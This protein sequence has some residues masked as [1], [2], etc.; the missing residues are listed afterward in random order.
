MDAR[1]EAR[2]MESVS[3][4][5]QSGIAQKRNGS[6]TQWLFGQMLDRIQQGAWPVG[7]SIPAERELLAEFGVSR[8]P[9]REALSMLRGLGILDIAHGRKGIVRPVDSDLLGRL[10]P[11]MLSLEGPQ[12]FRQVFEVRLAIESQTAYSA[13]ERRTE[14]D[15]DRLTELVER[16]REQVNQDT[17]QASQTDLE[18]HQAIAHSTGNPLLPALLKALSGFVLFAQG[19]SFKHDI[20]RARRAAEA[21]EMIADA[22]R[23]QDAQWAR[24]A[25]EAHLRYAAGGVLQDEISLRVLPE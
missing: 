22:I 6:T 23:M 12:T 13:A 14:E 25:M 15:V 8:F 7:E 2:L 10:F 3:M 24:A 18:F 19:E 21:H 4:S 20:Q 5:R 9:L 17:A 11:L 1:V 16:F